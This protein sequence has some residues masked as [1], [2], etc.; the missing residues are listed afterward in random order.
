V[1]ER[2]AGLTPEQQLQRDVAK[3]AGLY[4]AGTRGRN[5]ALWAAGEIYQACKRNPDRYGLK[6]H[7][8]LLELGKLLGWSEGKVHT[9]VL[10]RETY[11]ADEMRDYGA[12]PTQVLLEGVAIPKSPRNELLAKFLER[13][14]Q[15][16]L[17]GQDMVK[18]I[19]DRAQEVRALPDATGRAR[20]SRAGSKL[21]IGRLGRSAVKLIVCSREVLAGLGGGL[22][23]SPDDV[24]TIEGVVENVQN[25]MAELRAAV[26]R[27]V[28]QEAGV[29]PETG[30]AGSAE[31]PRMG[32][33]SSS[34]VRGVVDARE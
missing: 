34:E 20:A 8:S 22:A 31:L 2:D 4:A 6:K 32:G 3:V 19:R 27:Q 10:I 16:P 13:R 18:E 24:E 28:R 1:I 30:L 12:L 29:A 5:Y 9:A 21:P 26:D 14:A 7:L 17:E 23:L 11:T 33:D 15:E 25:V